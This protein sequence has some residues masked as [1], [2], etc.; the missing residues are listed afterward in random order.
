MQEKFRGAVTADM[1]CDD[2]HRYKEDIAIVKQLNLKSYRFSI[3]WP[4]VQ[5][6]GTDAPNPKGLDHC[7]RLVDTLLEAGI[8]PFCAMYHRQRYGFTYVDFRSQQRTVKDS[9][10]WYGKVVAAGRLDVA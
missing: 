7:S 4:R 1:A 3:A 5:P 8:R 10:L 6:R 9:E 2:Y